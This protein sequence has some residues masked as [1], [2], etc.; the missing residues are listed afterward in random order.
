MPLLFSH[1]FFHFSYCLAPVILRILPPQFMIPV[2]S[3][4][5]EGNGKLL[6]LLLVSLLFE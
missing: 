3:D 2:T 6:F 4:H 1:I 5:E